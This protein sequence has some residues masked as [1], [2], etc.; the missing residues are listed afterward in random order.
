MQK[1][2]GLSIPNKD[3][4]LDY[5]SPDLR[6]NAVAIAPLIL[7]PRNPRQGDVDLVAGSL[8]S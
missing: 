3:E 5:I 2:K 6:A 8:L 4:V 1:R 7:D